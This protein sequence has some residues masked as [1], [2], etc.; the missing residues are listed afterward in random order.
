[1][2]NVPIINFPLSFNAAATSNPNS[3][4]SAPSQIMF[5]HYSGL[6]NM[7]RNYLTGSG[8]VFDI[9][10]N[11]PD[12]IFDVTPTE[13]IPGQRDYNSASLAFIEGVINADLSATINV[14]YND[15]QMPDP[16]TFSFGPAIGAV[17][18]APGSIL[19][20]GNANCSTGP[21]FFDNFSLFQP[22][23][24]VSIEL[25]LEFRLPRIA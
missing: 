15:G 17:S 20:L 13:P 16:V 8:T 2:A 9:T 4:I 18:T 3:V 7:V 19:V 1:M 11:L 25:P 14:H 22:V 23:L 6:R 24:Q 5:T 21:H 12:L 10:P